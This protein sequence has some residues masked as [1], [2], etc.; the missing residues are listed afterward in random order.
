MASRVCQ[1]GVRDRRRKV[2]GASAEGG[3]G[4]RELPCQTAIGGRHK[5]CRL[6]MPAQDELDPTVFLDGLHEVQVL[7]AGDAKDILDTFGGERL[8][9]LVCCVHG[10]SSFSD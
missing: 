1:I 7:I 6:L 5:A 3:H 8:D 10:A 2:R 4:D 9:Q